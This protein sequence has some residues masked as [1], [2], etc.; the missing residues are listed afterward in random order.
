MCLSANLQ[1]RSEMCCTQLAENTGC[2]NSP[3]ICHLHTIVQLYRA[4]SS[5][6][7]HVSTIRKKLVKEQYNISSTCPYN[8]V[9]FRPLTAEIVWRVWSTTVNFNGFC[10]LASLLHRH[11]STEVNQTLH[12]VW[13][14]PGLVHYIYILGALASNGILPGAKFTLRP[15]LA[16]FYIG[17][18]TA[19]HSSSGRQPSFAMWSHMELQ[20]FRSSWFLTEGTT[21]ILRAAIT[22]G[23]HGNS[24]INHHPHSSLHLKTSKIWNAEF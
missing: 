12:D 2:K 6:L 3:K 8:M 7:R 4:I 21:Y 17:S 10:V 15:S 1:C 9:N 19:W 22:L 23:Y 13:P 11:R 14:S 20:N 5:Q 24:I 18:I 16:F